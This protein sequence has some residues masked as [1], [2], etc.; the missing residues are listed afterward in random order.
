MPKEQLFGIA[1]VKHVSCCSVQQ[2]CSYVDFGIS[3]TCQHRLH[4]SLS[5]VQTSR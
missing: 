5:K 4:R 3:I 2:D 1:F